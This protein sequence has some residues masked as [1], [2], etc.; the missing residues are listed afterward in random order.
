MALSRSRSNIL[1]SRTSVA[2]VVGLGLVLPMLGWPGVSSALAGRSRALYYETETRAGTLAIDRLSLSP[3]GASTQVVGLGDVNLFGIAL[4]GPYIYW[5]T[6]AGPKDRGAIMRATLD[7]GD[8]R[9]LVTGLPGPA[10]LIVVHGFLY[11]VDQ[12]AIGRVA[13]D[14]SDLRRRVIVPPPEPGGSVADGLA[15]DG[16]HL[17][18]TRCT[19]DEI[20]RASLNGGRIDLG[21]ISLG[22]DSCPQGIAVAGG[23]LYWTQLPSGTIGRATVGGRDANGRWL[24]IHSAQGPFQVVADRTH[25]YWTW[26]GVAGTPSYTGRADANGSH[27]VAR[28]LTDSLFPMALAASEP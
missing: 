27:L 21:Y 1:P 12:D 25:V 7:G 20:S 13:L 3:P 6:Q 22:P 11:W 2:V 14:G 4:G 23:H 15:S 28:F 5:S 9:P 17:Y 10:G 26:G 8:V 18:F 24:A 16:R 19:D